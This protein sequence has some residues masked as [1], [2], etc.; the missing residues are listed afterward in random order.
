MAQE[1]LEG[2]RWNLRMADRPIAMS[3]YDHS[4]V[5]LCIR[6]PILS[7]S[8]PDL[9]RSFFKRRQTMESSPKLQNLRESRRDSDKVAPVPLNPTQA[10]WALSHSF[11]ALVTEEL[12][13]SPRDCVMHMGGWLAE[14]F[15][16][17]RAEPCNTNP[18]WS[19]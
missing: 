11:S 13:L 12:S 4:G 6:A 17:F 3:L 10:L 15:S 16:T 18:N 5:I 14:A 2:S 9:I 7:H 19:Q 8:L 1:G